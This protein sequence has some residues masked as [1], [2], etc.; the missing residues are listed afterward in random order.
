MQAKILFCFEDF[1]VDLQKD[2]SQKIESS[3]EI[4][5]EDYQEPKIKLMIAIE[6]EE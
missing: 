5:E 1:N 3:D 2:I 4:E 6:E